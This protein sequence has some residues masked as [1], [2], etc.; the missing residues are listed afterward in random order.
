MNNI[1]EKN[2]FDAIV[3]GSGT[4]GATIAR[5]LGKQMKKVLILERG[6]N[7]PLKESFMGI[8]A[9]ADQVVLGDGK[10]STV[11]AI[12]TGGSTS[13]YFGVA[14][15]PQP[16]TFRAL[17]IDISQELEAVKQ[18]LPIAQL[19]DELL[20][21]QARKLRDSAIALG[22]AW[23][24]NDMLID[25]SKCASGYAY[26]AKWKA[27]SYVEEAVQLGAILINRATVQSIIVE[28]KVAIGVEYRIKTGLFRSE[29]RRAFGAK[30]ILAAGELASPKILRDSGVKGVGDRGFYCNPG[31]AI[32]GIVPGLKGTSG[33]VGSTGCVYEDG[34]ELGDANIPQPLHRPMMLGGLKLRHLLAFPETVGIGVKVKDGLAGELKDDGRFYKGF[35][36][37][38]LLMLSKGKQE[39]IKILEKAGAENI[40]DFGLTAAGRVGG[41]IRI[42]EHLDDKLET[43]YRNL[44][45]CDGSVIPD[46]MRGTPTITLVCLGKYLSKHLLSTF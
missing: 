36:R 5:E 23:Q 34:I 19:P 12:A 13:L 40:V 43:Q 3:V 17:G 22:H 44:H 8:V 1:H 16:D 18:E 41:L 6:G 14:N 20:N 33:F 42:G 21:A 25:V 30:I 37:E 2:E 31:Y 7:S 29:V 39:A 15:Y 24:K 4:C 35:D 26:E 46:D 32:Y 45:V 11:R 9:I 27:K 10:L 28:N 38:D